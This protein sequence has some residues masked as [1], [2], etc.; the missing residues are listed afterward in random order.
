MLVVLG[1]ELSAESSG[2]LDE[3]QIGFGLGG[4]GV[5]LRIAF[6]KINGGVD[7]VDLETRD[8]IHSLYFT[9]ATV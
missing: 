9:G 8:L 4:Y 6:I 5:H 3:T 7:A 2:G 1:L